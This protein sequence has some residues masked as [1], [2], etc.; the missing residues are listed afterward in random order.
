MSTPGNMMQQLLAPW[1]TG[2]ASSSIDNSLADYGGYTGLLSALMQGAGP[3]TSQART[4]AALM[5]A[6]TNALNNAGARQQLAQGSIGLQQSLQTQALLNEAI[7]RWQAQQAAQSAPQSQ[8]PAMPG[9]FGEPSQ[10]PSPVGAQ[11]SPPQASGT[12]SQQPQQFAGAQDISQIPINGLSPDLYR[13][14][15]MAKGKFGVPLEQEI[16]NYQLQVA[17]QQ[18]KPAL[19]SLD[20]LIKS[21]YDP[22]PA[23]RAN[24]FLQQA[25][26]QG[27]KLS[28]LDPTDFSDP[29]KVRLGLAAYRNQIAGN[30]QVAPV[31]PAVRKVVWEDVGDA[32]NPVYADTGE[33]VPGIK[34]MPKHL[35]P[36]QSAGASGLNDDSKEMAYQYYLQH[37]ALPPGFSRNPL[38]NA[39][40]M[41]YISQ[42]AK[43]DGNSQVSILAN[44]QQVKA[45]QGVLKDFE[46]GQTSKTL[47]GLNT[48]ISHMDQLEQA[49]TALQNGNVQALNRMGNFFK[50][51]FGSSAQ[52]NFDVVKNFAAGEVAKAVL[53]GGGGERERE[54]IAAAVKNSASPTQLHDA[55]QMWRNL[56]AGKTE[57]LRN[58][59]D[60]GTSGTQG[61]F[62]KFLLPA[63]KKALGI[64]DQP[65]APVGVGQSQSLGGFTVTRVK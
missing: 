39:Q 56:L 60:V 51:Q 11:P 26:Q 12:T 24:P 9:P 47:N 5:N 25:W 3:N 15:S 27:A 21:P 44:A 4:G 19:D 58:Q 36:M 50:T 41:N 17:Q 2:A 30:A 42:R 45:S 34:P 40:V 46:S 13:A 38:M 53:P 1:M 43:Q 29:N 28:G 35:T 14:L 49:S 59:W 10:T 62:D 65:A 31:E 16:R 6:Q 61:S 54:E 32:K 18:A 7:K 48:A 57:A 23:I 55:I 22:S 33:P 37:Q 20:T 8:A 63:T 52:T 64:S